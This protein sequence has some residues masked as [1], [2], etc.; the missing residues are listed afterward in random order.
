MNS[1]K[2]FHRDFRMLNGSPGEIL[3]LLEE[4]NLKAEFHYRP[5]RSQICCSAIDAK[6]EL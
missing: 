1:L 2:E 6:M 4:E 5:G 3:L